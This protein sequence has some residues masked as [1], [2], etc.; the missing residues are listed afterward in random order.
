MYWNYMYRESL[1]TGN[2]VLEVCIVFG[3]K[4]LVCYNGNFK[5]ILLTYFTITFP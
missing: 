5:Q 2:A 1:N 3:Y 4:N